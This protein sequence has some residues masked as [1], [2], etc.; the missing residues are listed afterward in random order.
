[1]LPRVSPDSAPVTLMSA[2]ARVSAPLLSDVI[3]FFF[4][5]ISSILFSISDQES[6]SGA[7]ESMTTDALSAGNSNILN[8]WNKS[9]VAVEDHHFTFPKYYF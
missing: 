8:Q 6:S 2:E 7:E 9:S 5:N 4:Q 1:M 3:I